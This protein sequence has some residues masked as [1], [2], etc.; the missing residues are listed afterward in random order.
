MLTRVLGAPEMK[1]AGIYLHKKIGE[2]AKKGEPICTFYTDSVYNLKEGKET[3]K[4]FPFYTL[5]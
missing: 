3:L 1:T 2:K 4:N 5:K